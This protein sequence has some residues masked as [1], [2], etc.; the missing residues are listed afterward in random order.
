MLHK[1][2]DLGFNPE[3]PHENAG[4]GNTT[5]KRLRQDNFSGW[6]ASR[7][8]LIGRLSASKRTLSK[9][10]KELDSVLKIKLKTVFVSTHT[11]NTHKN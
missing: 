5:L 3:I 7:Q 10:V 6:P 2:E 9:E 1:C 4:H 11:Y 8:S